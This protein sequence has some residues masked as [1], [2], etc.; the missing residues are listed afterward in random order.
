MRRTSNIHLSLTLKNPS[1]A[2]TYI[3]YT[4]YIAT[5]VFLRGLY[6]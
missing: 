3:K 6:Q 5:S 1:K 4:M 2:Y